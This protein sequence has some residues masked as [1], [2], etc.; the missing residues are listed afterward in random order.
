T[1]WSSTQATFSV[2]D[3]VAEG[4]GIPKSRVTVITEYMGGGFGSKFGAG[5]FSLIAARLAKQAK[6]PV[7]LM[8]TRKEQRLGTGNRTNSVMRLKIGGKKSGSLDAVHLVSYGTPGVG[9]GAGVSGPVRNTYEISNV[10]AE[11]TD[12]HTNTG[13]AAPFRAPGHPQG[14]FAYEQAI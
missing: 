2:R 1:V 3:E 11:E 5:S 8:L 10:R 9:T 14:A 13:P 6:A 4:L 12:V 7:K